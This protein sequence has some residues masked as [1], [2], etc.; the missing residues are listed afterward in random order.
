LIDIKEDSRQDIVKIVRGEIKDIK[1]KDSFSTLTS[2]LT[3]NWVIIVAFVT[4]IFWIYQSINSI[5]THNLQ[6][7][8]QIQV[9]TSQQEINTKS[10]TELTEIVDELDD[11]Q[12]SIQRDISEINI[13][14]EDISRLLED[15]KNN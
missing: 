2:G 15:I 5:Q 1:D 9:I 8:N 11:N 7:D 14:L 4:G 6:Q 10:I 13:S 3:E 12:S